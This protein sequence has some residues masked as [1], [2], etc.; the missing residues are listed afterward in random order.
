MTAVVSGTLSN[1]NFDGTGQTFSGTV[2]GELTGTASRSAASLTG[3]LAVTW[4]SDAN[5]NPTI[6]PV[7]ISTSSGTYNIVGTIG[8]GAGAGTGEQLWASYAKIGTSKINGG[9]S[10]KILGSKPFGI[11]ENLG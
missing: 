9:T 1:C 5:L 7:S 10:E 4:P 8:A 11:F 2:F 6:S 3:N